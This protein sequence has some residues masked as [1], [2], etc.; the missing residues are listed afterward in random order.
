MDWKAKAAAISPLLGLAQ[1][2]QWG[3]EAGVLGKIFG[4]VGDRGKFAVEFGQRTIGSGTVGQLIAQRGWGALYMDREADTAARPAVATGAP[5]IT[6]ARESV[7]PSNI[8]ALFA[9]YAVPHDLDCLVIDIDGIDYWV[10][11]ALSAE[12]APSLVVIEF[13]AHV[14]L[15]VEATIHNDE[16]WAYL[17]GKNYGASF[18]AL[19]A[20]VAGK[21]YR[22]IHVHGPWNLYF[23][24]GDI[25]FPSEWCI[26]APLSTAEL[27]VL[28]QTEPFYDALCGVGRRPT[29]YGAEAPEVSMAPWHIVAPDTPSKRLDIG[30]INLE[31]LADKHDVQWYQQ[32]KTFE[33]RV[34]LLYGFIRDE[35]FTHFVDVG[36]N[37]GFVSIVASQAAKHLK[38]VAI[39]AD[40]RLV[41]L[42]RQNFLANGVDGV[43]SS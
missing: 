25:P 42:M 2:G 32:R 18:S 39:E 12:Y 34:S 5:Q 13:N 9:R 27:E 14:P 4:Q 29:W 15:G 8:N 7:S 3:G 16:N 10:L 6:L 37:V 23:L 31:V 11:R 35:G 20:L 40:P 41:Q 26:K 43:P 33:E 24:R 36:A 22:L 28:T 17:P 38:I 19:C 21:A 30:G 1:V